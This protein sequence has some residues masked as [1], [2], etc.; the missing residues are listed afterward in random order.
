MKKFYIREVNYF[1]GGG[2]AAAG[3]LLACA[4]KQVR[5]FFFLLL[6]GINPAPPASSLQLAMADIRCCFTSE[7]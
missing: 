3:H 1:K 7:F 4:R 5:A 6:T 2:A